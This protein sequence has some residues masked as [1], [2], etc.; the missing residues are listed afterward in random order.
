MVVGS[1]IF[2]ASLGSGSGGVLAA[3]IA[4]N[5]FGTVPLSRVTKNLGGGVWNSS[6]YTYEIPISGT[7]LIKSSVRL[8]DNSTGNNSPVRNIYQAVGTENR[9]IP[10]GIWQ[11]NYDRTT[12]PT[13]TG[14][15]RFTMLYNRIAYFDK[16][17]KVRLYIYSDGAEAKLSDASLD[18]VLISAN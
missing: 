9:D 16:G 8:M 18:I 10:E 17:S 2:T 14:Y 1:A 12:I 7:Y 13:G 5:G 11:T 3:T 4:Q 6:D 15:N